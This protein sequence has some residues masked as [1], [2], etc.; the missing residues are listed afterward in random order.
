MTAT[1]HP[2]AAPSSGSTHEA[3]GTLATL[4]RR[5]LELGLG[6]SSLEACL[7][8]R[9]VPDST[10][11]GFASRETPSFPAHTPL[12][13]RTKLPGFPL[14]SGEEAQAP[15]RRRAW[16]APP[17]AR[18]R[19]GPAPRLPAGAERG[20]RHRLR[21]AGTPPAVP[22]APAAGRRGAAE[23]RPRGA[24][25][26]TPTC[27]SCACPRPAEAFRLAPPGFPGDPTL[28]GFSASFP[29]FGA[30][31][32]SLLRRPSSGATSARPAAQHTVSR[33]HEAAPPAPVPHSPFF[34]GRWV[35]LTARPPAS[36]EGAAREHPLAP[37]LSPS[38]T[39]ITA[40]SSA[41]HPRHSSGRFCF[42][43]LTLTPEPTFTDART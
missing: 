13:P 22:P 38:L 25:S 34:C 17:G 35:S 7:S 12:H 20:S 14:P 37:S 24:G 29:V 26:S 41:N 31:L 42:L 21:P 1:C 18:P 30:S 5:S 27:L 16:R 4:P 40:P 28:P 36:L 15:G 19:C 6:C 39:V 10:M 32:A 8:H 9:S 3:P 43:F 33:C 11:P 23:R 2:T